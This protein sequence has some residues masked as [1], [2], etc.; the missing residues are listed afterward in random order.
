[1]C[2]EEIAADGVLSR[3]VV[4]DQRKLLLAQSMLYA[5]L[6]LYTNRVLRDIRMLSWS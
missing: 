1:V 5:V 4:A 6:P 3:H 2:F